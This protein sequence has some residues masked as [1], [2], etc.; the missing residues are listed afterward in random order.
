MK[1]FSKELA[2]A[3]TKASKRNLNEAKTYS[4]GM[5][6]HHVERM[7]K[8]LTVLTV[9]AASIAGAYFTTLYKKKD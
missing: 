7:D 4:T 9:I 3:V 1:S 6:M 8:S 5:I 2:D